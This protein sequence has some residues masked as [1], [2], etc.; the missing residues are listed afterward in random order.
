MLT[1]KQ[2][3]SLPDCFKNIPDPRRA[4]GDAIVCQWCWPLRLV[5]FC[6]ACAA[7]VPSRNGPTRWDRKH[8][9]GLVA[10]V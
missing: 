5:R 8:G 6:A 7:T 10:A 4:Q 9:R 3:C 2:M 1:A